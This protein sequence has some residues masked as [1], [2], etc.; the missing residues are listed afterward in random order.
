[1]TGT[2]RHSRG[3]DRAIA[4]AWIR[5]HVDP[6]G[7]IRT[8]HERPWATVRRAP[9][10]HGAPWFKACSPAQACEPRLSAEPFARWPDRV[11]E[12]LAHDDERAWL[13]LADA[14]T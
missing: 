13:L 12:V 2:R 3:V 14:G 5:A 4:E 6:A 8:A 9:L 7:A 1:M 10:A 11:A